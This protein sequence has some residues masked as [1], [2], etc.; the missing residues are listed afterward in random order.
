MRKTSLDKNRT[1]LAVWAG[2]SLAAAMPLLGSCGGDTM[3]TGTLQ[4]YE[5]CGDPVCRGYT[6]P[7]GVALCSTQKVG[8]VCTTAGQTCDPK[9]MCNQLYI[10]STTD[11]KRAPGGCPISRR[12][13]KTEI[14]YLD[15]ADVSRYADELSRVKL[16]T[17]RYKGGG[18]THLGFILEDQEPSVSVD[19][20]RDMVDLYGY[21]S[22]TVAAVQAQ[23]KKL[24][25]LQAELS[26][27]RTELAQ[28]LRSQ[29]KR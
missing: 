27:L 11:P 25:A 9:S 29:R 21:T 3:P 28:A 15:A 14:K 19:S 23:E 22:L 12:K 26:A 2:L 16:A 24:A 20:A 6:A 7:V 13:Y 8:D 5:T 1:R 10:C 18:P 4:I 17:Y